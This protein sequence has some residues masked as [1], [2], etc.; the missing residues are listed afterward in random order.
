M[1]FPCRKTKYARELE[2][3]AESAT[4]PS[5]FVQVTDNPA[6]YT[7]TEVLRSQYNQSSEGIVEDND[8]DQLPALKPST[9]QVDVDNDHDELPTAVK[10]SPTQG[11]K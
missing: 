7:S 4:K 1:H 2:R 8:Y 3:M 9:V 5:S 10:R 11:Q 6:H